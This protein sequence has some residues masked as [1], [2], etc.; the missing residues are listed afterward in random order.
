MIGIQNANGFFSFW[1][2]RCR[3]CLI[4]WQCGLMLDMLE[5]INKLHPLERFLVILGA[6]VCLLTTVMVWRS[7][8][9]YQAMW[10]LP[11]W[12]FIEMAALAMLSAL[13]F[14]RG[15]PAGKF[16][17]WCAVGIFAAFSVLGA[18]SVGLL[19]LPITVLFATAA[20]SFDVRN[21]QHVL[22]HLAVC[23]LAALT[24]VALM[25]T[26]IRLLDPASLF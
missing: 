8:S 10:P 16:V 11:G 1:L 5:T 6:G 2:Q 18:F 13:A 19:Y 12:Y 7:V 17:A 20:I 22:A 14:I 25:L 3:L 15:G 24:Q 21:G 23:I 26:V 9:G 4:P